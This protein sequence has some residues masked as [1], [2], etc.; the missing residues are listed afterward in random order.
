MYG[1][2]EAEEEG[3]RFR[4]AYEEGRYDCMEVTGAERKANKMGVYE[5][6]G[7]RSNGRR[8]YKHAKQ[9]VYLYHVPIDKPSPNTSAAPCAPSSHFPR[10]PAIVLREREQ[11]SCAP[12]RHFRV[13]L[14]R[15]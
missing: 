1:V 7:R 10:H 5:W 13:L 12:G 9:M 14:L 2:V 11:R 15:S 4:V 3:G 8:V 6:T